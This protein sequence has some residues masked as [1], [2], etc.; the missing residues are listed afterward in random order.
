VRKSLLKILPQ[1]RWFSIGGKRN[2]EIQQW[3]QW[4]ISGDAVTAVECAG[5]AVRSDS[6]Q[7]GAIVPTSHQA[8]HLALGFADNRQRNRTIDWHKN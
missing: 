8:F 6:Q 5:I 3:S 2:V 7:A 1:L 4:Y